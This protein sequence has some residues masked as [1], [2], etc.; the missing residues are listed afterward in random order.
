[1]GHRKRDLQYWGPLL[2]IW[3]YHT[4]TV[5][6]AVAAAVAVDCASRFNWSA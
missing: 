6:A 3:M 5:A 4:A 2:I 1:M